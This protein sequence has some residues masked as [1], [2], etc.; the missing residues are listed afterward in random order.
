MDFNV[1]QI[2]ISLCDMI[3]GVPRPLARPSSP[4][5][6]SQVCCV[7]SESL[8]LPV[9]EMETMSKSPLSR[10]LNEKQLKVLM[11]QSGM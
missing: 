9:S 8:G 7:S 4:R 5:F 11:V 3:C 2:L 6:E 10:G 1:E